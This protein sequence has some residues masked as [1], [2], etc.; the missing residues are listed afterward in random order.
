ML[1]KLKDVIK[2]L[3]SDHYLIPKEQIERWR[4]DLFNMENKVHTVSNNIYY[5]LMGRIDSM[6][7]VVKKILD[8]N[9]KN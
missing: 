6:S 7:K 9:K 8:Y 5:V 2:V 3:S 1:N 4:E